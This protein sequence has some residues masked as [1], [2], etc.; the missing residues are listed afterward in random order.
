MVSLGLVEVLLI[1]ILASSIIPLPSEF[2]LLT[3]GMMSVDVIQAS[4]LGGIGLTLGSLITYWFGSKFGRKFIEKFGKYVFLTEERMKVLARW[5]EKYGKASLFLGRI[6]PIVPHKVHSLVAGI[7]GIR[8]RDFLILTL[9]GSIP[10]CYL[11]VSFGSF[12]INFKNIPLIV[13]STLITF[14]L[15]LFFEKVVGI[16]KFKS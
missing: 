3:V 15:P 11:L 13:F 1:T 10:R 5:F 12:L 14:F 16:L 7:F 2:L 6:L 8:L 9:I 4:I